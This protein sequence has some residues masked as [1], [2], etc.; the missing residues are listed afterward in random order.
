MP[1]PPMPAAREKSS[2]LEAGL[3]F[4]L[5]ELAATRE[6]VRAVFAQCL[7]TPEAIARR[8]GRDVSA[9]ESFPKGQKPPLP[10]DYKLL[11]VVPHPSVVLVVGKRG[12]GKSALAYR[13]LELFR[14]LAD[15]Y[16]LGV[17]GQGRRILPDWIGMADDLA[18]APHGS[19]VVVDEAYLLYHSRRSLTGQ[20]RNMSQII[21]LSRQRRQTL[22]FVTPEARQLD[23]N[24][25]SAANVLIF[26]VPGMFQPEF[27]RPEL[28]KVAAQAKEAF[29]DIK[30]DKRGWS[31]VYSPDA[32]FAGLLENSLP[33]FWSHN[34]SR[35]FASGAGKG[36]VRPARKMTREERIEK[37]MELRRSGL[38]F[39]E[40][41]RVLGVT[42]GT[43]YNYI[44]GYPYG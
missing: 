6:R 15:P 4:S 3:R 33:S 26:K 32:E 23:R 12:S 10:L 1:P 24:I 20:N 30:G 13:L 14:Y 27:D 43:A 21:N 42:K 18:G 25:S 2:D 37:A 36:G 16:V 7:G 39:K 38:S 44:K 19:V 41:G 8:T 28:N 35:I 29:R 31:F 9:P 40:I 22:V 5:A 11:Q 34:L 17:P